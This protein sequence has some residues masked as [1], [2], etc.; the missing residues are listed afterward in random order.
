MKSLMKSA[1]KFT[2]FAILLVACLLWVGGCSTS[3]MHLLY[4]TSVIAD[5]YRYGDLYRLSNLPQFKDPAVPCPPRPVA[6]DS[7]RT[8]LYVIGDSFTEPARLSK[9]DF[10]VAYYQRVQW[11]KPDTIQLDPSAHNVLLIE[12]VERHF[13]EHAAAGPAEPIR[14]LVVVNDTNR[15]ASPELVS[16]PLGKQFVDFIHAQGIEERLETIL[17]SHDIFLWFKELKASLTLSV[18]DRV[19]PNVSLS[20]N[21]QHVF[22][23]L[24]TDSTK[25]LNAG[26]SLLSGQEVTALV[27]TINK[28]AA[29]YTAAGFD[30]VLLS[31][32]PNKA[33]ILDPT[34]KPYNHLIERVQNHPALSVPVVDVY[35]PYRQ[36]PQSVYA[37]GDSHWNCTG[38]AIWLDAVAKQLR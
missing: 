29:R 11:N 10:P 8:H 16:T 38:R 30:R 7:G 36:Q 9:Q 33:T 26:T 24:D 14:E 13:R 19:S 20:Q 28:A 4:E 32:I 34:R 2:K 23:A 1:M 3:V 21:G 27:S 25:R 37:R 6:A 31:I 22:I 35:S 18:F 12:S 15:T 17:F 5:D